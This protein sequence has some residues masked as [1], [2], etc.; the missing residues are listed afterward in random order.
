MFFKYEI[1]YLCNQSFSPNV[2]DVCDL[3][4]GNS[5][6]SGF[7]TR[8]DGSVENLAVNATMTRAACSVNDVFFTEANR[9]SRLNVANN[10]WFPVIRDLI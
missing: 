1:R 6:G 2:P 9:L 10:Y 7:R 5:D 3:F 8:D 4:V